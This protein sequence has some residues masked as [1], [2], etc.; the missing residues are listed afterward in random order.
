MTSSP[1]HRSQPVRICA[2]TDLAEGEARRFELDGGAVAVAMVDGEVFAIGD[3]CS[4]ADYSLSAGYLDRLEC[5]LEC[6]KHGSLFSLRTGDA[7]TLPA[8]IPVATYDVQI[9]NG[10]VWVT[11]PE[12]TSPDKDPQ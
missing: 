6:P 11:L 8:T 5:A 10:E 9:D 7:L 1:D 3:T 4:H 12:M 2:T